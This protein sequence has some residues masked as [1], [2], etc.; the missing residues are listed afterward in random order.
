MR[1]ATCSCACVMTKAFSIFAFALLA[2]GGAIDQNKSDAGGDGGG[3]KDAGGDASNRVPKNHRATG[4]TC[5]TG[6]GSDDGQ[7]GDSGVPGTCSHDSDCTSGKN[8][9]CTPNM[10]GAFTLTCTY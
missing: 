5:P 9:R 6:R 8:G 10:G 1:H 7:F 2:C 4:A 3:Q